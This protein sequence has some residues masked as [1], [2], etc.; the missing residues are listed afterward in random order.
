[1]NNNSFLV[2]GDIM[3]NK[4]IKIANDQMGFTIIE[5]LIAISILTVGLLAVATMQVSAIRGNNLSDNVTI[6]LALAEDKMESLMIT[7]YSDPDLQDTEAG[8]NTNLTSITTI[9]HEELNIDETGAAGGD[10]RRIW[11]IADNEPI[12]SNKTISIIVTWN[13]GQHKVVISSIKRL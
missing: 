11:N 8:N 3:R 1:M 10:F 6:A 13:N 2:N 7:D 9:D 12:T 5:I 4:N